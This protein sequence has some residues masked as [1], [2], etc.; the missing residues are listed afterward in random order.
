MTLITRSQRH[1]FS[2]FSIVS[3]SCLWVGRIA[4]AVHQQVMARRRARLLQQTVTVTAKPIAPIIL[5]PVEQELIQISEQVSHEM[6]GHFQPVLQDE[7]TRQDTKTGQPEL[8][9]GQLIEALLDEAWGRG[10]ITYPQLIAYVTEQ[11]G[12]GC[13]RRAIAAWKKQRGLA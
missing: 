2:L 3:A 10:H 4:Q 6:T 12:T 13:S 5:T 9:R 1:S 8:T 11:T 7:H